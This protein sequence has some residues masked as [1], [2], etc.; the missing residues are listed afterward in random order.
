VR[1]RESESLKEKI[2][3]DREA[4]KMNH[5]QVSKRRKTLIGSLD[6]LVEKKEGHVGEVLKVRVMWT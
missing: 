2:K 1:S 5:G 6:H 4:R 3:E